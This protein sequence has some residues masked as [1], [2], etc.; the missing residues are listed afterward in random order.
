FTNIRE[1]DPVLCMV[2][3]SATG[4]FKDGLGRF[5]TT[6][7]ALYLSSGTRTKNTGEV[8]PVLCMVFASATG[9]FKDGLGRFITTPNTLY[10]SS[11]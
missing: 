3:S 8:D 11:S 6:P 9:P 2:F 1:E 4:P 5:I 7:S 10:L